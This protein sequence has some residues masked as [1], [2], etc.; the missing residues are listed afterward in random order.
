MRVENHNVIIPMPD[1]TELV[2]A[3]NAFED[4]LKGKLVELSKLQERSREFV[5]ALAFLEEKGLLDDFNKK[6]NKLYKLESV[7]IN[8]DYKK[9]VNDIV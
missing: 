5:S 7:G 8:K 1:Y 4:K 6:M 9:L 2:N 3:K